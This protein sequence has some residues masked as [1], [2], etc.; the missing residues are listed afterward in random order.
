MVGV[1]S[2]ILL[3]VLSDG[4]KRWIEESTKGSLFRE[5]TIESLQ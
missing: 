2:V 5:F 3:D 4:V 1:F